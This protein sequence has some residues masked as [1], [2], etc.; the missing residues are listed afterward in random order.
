MASL[1][2]LDYHGVPFSCLLT[3]IYSSTA[4]GNGFQSGACAGGILCMQQGRGA[5]RQLPLG[6]RP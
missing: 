6:S 1:E 4:R 3:L 5:D 2:L